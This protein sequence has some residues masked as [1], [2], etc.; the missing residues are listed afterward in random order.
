MTPRPAARTD[1]AGRDRAPTLLGRHRRAGWVLTLVMLAAACNGK[2]ASGPFAQFGKATVT[3]ADARVLSVLVADTD[4]LR[5]QGLGGVTDLAGYDAML[6]RFP[7]DTDTQ[8]WMKDTKIVLDIA[9]V[10]ADGTVLR[11]LTMPV[12][13]S[14]DDNCERYGPGARYRF[15]LEA[16]AGSFARWN[17]VAGGR[18]IIP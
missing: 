9:F 4:G 17:L 7:S 16:P 8:F 18:M 1:A 12:C 10:A 13:A 15:A 6:F 2:S 3:V 5:Q 14:N 11:T